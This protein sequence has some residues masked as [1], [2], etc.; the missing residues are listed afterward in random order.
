MKTTALFGLIVLNITFIVSSAAASATTYSSR[1]AYLAAAG[2]L[3]TETSIDFSTRDDGTPITNPGSDTYFDPLSLRGATFN[4]Q[5][6]YNSFIYVGPGGFITASLPANTRAFEVDLS[7]FYGSGGT[8][9]VT[10]STGQSYTIARSAGGPV[11]STAPSFFGITS[12]QPFAWAKF[13]YDGDYCVV[14]NFI[15]R[16]TPVVPT[17]TP[18]PYVSPISDLV[19]YW[20]ADGH[21]N[22]VV[23]PNNGIFQNGS[24]YAAGYVAQAFDLGSATRYVSVPDSPS[25]SLT[26]PM[27][28][29]ARIKVNTNSVQQA[30]IEKYDPPGV[31]G[32]LFRISGGKLSAAMCDSTLQGANHP[33]FGTTTITTGVWHN[34]AAVY[35]GSSIKVYLDGVLDGSAVSN[36][37]PTNGAASLKIGARGDDANTR[38]NGLI[39]E[40]K[41]YNRAL[42]VSEIQGPTSPAPTTS[43]AYIANQGTNS[44]EVLDLAT[45]ALI[46]NIPVGRVPAHIAVNSIGTRV[47]VTNATSNDVSVIDAGS[48][49]VIATVPVGD[50]PT[51]IAVTPDDS[52]VYVVN[53]R[54]NSVFVMDAATNQ[55][56]SSVALFGNPEGIAI[57]PDGS[58]AYVAS[59]NGNCVF[60]IDTASNM[61]AA[62]IPIP[63]LPPYADILPSGVKITP[64]GSLAV[65]SD[66]RGAALT[67]INTATNSIISTIV[68][69]GFNARTVDLSPDGHTAYVAVEGGG[70]LAVV[71]LT[72]FT[73]TRQIHT[74][75]SPFS[76][77]VSRDGKRAYIADYNS[78]SF[79]IVD[80]VT[81]A[82][83]APLNIISGRAF[84]A[85]WEVPS[86]DST[87]PVILPTVTG[88]LGNDGWYTSSVS[89]SWSV[90]DGE[91]PVGPSTGCDAA[92]VSTDTSGITFTCS[93]TS[94]GGSNS[95]SVTVKRDATGP[96]ISCGSADGLWHAA[97]VS[98]GCTSN[99][100]GSG[101]ANA[102]D[103]NFNLATLVAAG[104]ETAN[105]STNSR[106]VCDVAGNCTTA[107]P[108][109]GNRIDKKAP[110]VTIA[111]PTGG[112]YLLNQTVA[113]SYTCADSGSGI[114][115][116]TGTTASGGQ[117][118][119]ASVGSHTFTVNAVDSAGNAASPVTVNYTVN[120]GILVLFDQTKAHKSGSAV[121]IKIRLVDANGVNLSGAGTVLD[122][123]S[124]MQVSSQANTT[125]DDAGS[126]NPD[127]DFRY[128]ASVGGYIFNLK[129]TGFGTGTYR[130]S[131]VAGGTGTQ[132][133]VDFQVRQ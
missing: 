76:L 70:N 89:V 83:S 111:A 1:S 102:G 79:A 6:Y 3:G 87:P 52:R 56:V 129:T 4:G 107:A 20:P 27:T 116:C 8:F 55:I 115:S 16:S 10:I 132:Y 39:D 77:A 130:L 53:D 122:A 49:T 54:G 28:L 69:G 17:P 26:G 95:Q 13:T 30:I 29:Q 7:A 82:V 19:S 100:A 109:S 92:T 34:V 33:V 66:L 105:A 113:V 22:D 11:F 114:A 5:S 124:V 73:I 133:N 59:L 125:L 68:L 97:D 9:T 99:D 121:P 74:G 108:I 93:A 91:S 94:G 120:F 46:G 51:G 60:V 64:D 61:L 44:I 96:N 31:N 36:F 127:F 84:V 117:L 2:S 131:F 32:Y 88:T 81:W 42:S 43:R 40:V 23:G 50:G 126:S 48:A 101:L 41:I 71:D 63:A 86:P 18:T 21:T 123:V 65:V 62:T 80:T 103:A 104:S 12:D 47:Y 98:I 112:S 25:L 58:R 78:P 15:Y 35:D 85:L 72:T 128:D 14:D 67:I 57:T 118:D 38:L 45:N 24:A 110:V 106:E 119:T 37:P 75:T 90:T